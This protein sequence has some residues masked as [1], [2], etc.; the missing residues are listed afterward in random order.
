MSQY[1]PDDNRFDLRQI[2]YNSSWVTQ[3]KAIDTLVE[4]HI[5]DQAD[6][7][8]EDEIDEE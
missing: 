6:D 5:N 2:L 8:T 3:F 7:E 1:S 4:S